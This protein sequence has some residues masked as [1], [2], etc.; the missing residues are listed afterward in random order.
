M[1]DKTPHNH[2]KEIEKF[3]FELAEELGII[4]QAGQGKRTRS[5]VAKPRRA[6]H[7]SR[8]NTKGP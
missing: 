2:E 1:A 6:P 7:A 4:E 8:A 5:T 3:R